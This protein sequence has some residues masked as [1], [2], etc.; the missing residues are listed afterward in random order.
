[1]KRKAKRSIAATVTLSTLWFSL[2]I[3]SPV[4]GATTTTDSP[5]TQAS[6]TK[7]EVSSGVPDADREEISKPR[8]TVGLV[9]KAR[10]RPE[11]LLAA[12]ALHA[13]SVCAVDDEYSRSGF[14][15]CVKYCL[16][17]AGVSP[18]S[19][20]ICGGS[21]ATGNVVI[22]ALCVGISVTVVQWCAIGCAVYG[23]GDGREEIHDGPVVQTRRPSGNRNLEHTAPNRH[24]TT[25]RS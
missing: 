25:V 18:V 21:C 3:A 14:G 6:K 7:T 12:K 2:S 23:R 22:C 10:L 24:L 15:S 16:A 20:V 19:L 13:H 4:M 17:D 1:M 5:K 11:K 8:K 9:G